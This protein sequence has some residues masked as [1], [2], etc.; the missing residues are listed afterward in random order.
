MCS[1]FWLFWLSCQ[2]LP[3][4]WL[5]IL[6]WGSLIVARDCFHKAQGGEHLR[7]SWFI[8]LV[9][10]LIVCLSYPR[11]YIIYFILLWHDIACLCWKCRYTPVNQTKPFI[12][13]S[14][15]SVNYS[16]KELMNSVMFMC[17]CVSTVT[18]ILTQ[19]WFGNRHRACKQYILPVTSLSCSSPQRFLEEL[20]ETWSPGVIFGKTGQLNK[21]PK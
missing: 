21:S 19:C 15:K 2:Y 11:P 1:V 4:D 6:V 9:H 12:L 8:V 20:R 18:N 16:A 14:T 3:S 5:E 10:C 7:F 13:L 17:L